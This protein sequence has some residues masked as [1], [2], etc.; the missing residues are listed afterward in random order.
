M[1][2]VQSNEGYRLTMVALKLNIQDKEYGNCDLLSLNHGR[3][4]TTA[5]GD[6]TY[7]LSLN[8]GRVET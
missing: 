3:V 6:V 5:I 8:H 1:R 7:G 4:E 2:L